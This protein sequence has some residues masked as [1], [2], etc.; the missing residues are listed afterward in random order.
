MSVQQLLA[1]G[2][3]LTSCKRWFAGLGLTLVSGLV[4]AA[5]ISLQWDDNNPANGSE[6]VSQPDTVGGD[7][8]YVIGPETAA[9]GV[10]RTVLTVTS[11]EASL[12]VKQGDPLVTGT[13]VL[14][15]A[16]PGSDAVL[17]DQP[18]YSAGQGWYI[19]VN[20]QPGATWTLTSGDID[21]TDWGTVDATTDT[22]TAT[23]GP[24]GM[25]WFKV[26]MDPALVQAW[27]IMEKSPT[28]KAMYVSRGKA[29]MVT[30][31]KTV[32][33][34]KEETRGQMVATSS[35]QTATYYL[36][37][38]GNKGSTVALTAFKHNVIVPI[39]APTR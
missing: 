16:T 19:R 25:L 13:G 27:G 15:S 31:I 2:N 36:G 3:L 1:R 37:V 21:V 5:P 4:A 23:I 24:E 11:G 28:P 10:W 26:I 9:H 29:P 17:I 7:Y 12:Y 30:S 18:S 8:I 38:K 34:Q 22:S 33:D 20:A 32:A 39:H 6:A 35:G 14:S